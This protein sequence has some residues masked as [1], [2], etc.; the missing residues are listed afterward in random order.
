[1]RQK[2]LR[3]TLRGKYVFNFMIKFIRLLVEDSSNKQQQK[4]L[5]QKVKYTIDNSTALSLLTSYAETP[6]CLK[7]F[8]KQYNFE[9]R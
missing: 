8:I 9:N 1:M 2:D 7:K 6:I 3:L 5:K 4:I